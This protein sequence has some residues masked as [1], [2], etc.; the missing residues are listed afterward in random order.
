LAALASTF[1]TTRAVLAVA[2]GAGGWLA[3]LGAAAR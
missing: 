1:M 3:G 2:G